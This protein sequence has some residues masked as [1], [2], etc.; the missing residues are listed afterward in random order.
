M[1]NRIFAAS[2]W[3]GF[4]GVL[5]SLAQLVESGGANPVAWGA[6][7]SGIAAIIIPEKK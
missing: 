5:Y 6:L 1:F 2:S 4:A 3:A 7:I